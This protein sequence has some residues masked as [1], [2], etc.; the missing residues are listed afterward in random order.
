MLS[1]GLIKLPLL[2]QSMSLYPHKYAG[3]WVTLKNVEKIKWSRL[4]QNAEALLITFSH[5]L[6]TWEA[7]T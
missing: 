1:V 7:G 3:E 4:Y 6:A 5:F 2:S